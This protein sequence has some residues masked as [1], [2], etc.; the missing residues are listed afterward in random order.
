MPIKRNDAI[1]METDGL[2]DDITNLGTVE[3]LLGI[4]NK[5][6]R[7]AMRGTT[8]N[9]VLLIKRALIDQTR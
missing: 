4:K 5:K 7:Y 3:G 2:P 9:E 8:R 6:K 1:S